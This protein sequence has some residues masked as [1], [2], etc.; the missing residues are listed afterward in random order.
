[1]RAPP[2]AWGTRAAA[3]RSWMATTLSDS[4][5]A[6]SGR[7]TERGRSFAISSG[8]QSREP[9]LRRARANRDGVGELE[10]LAQDVTTLLVAGADPLGHRAGGVGDECVRTRR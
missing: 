7:W 3:R 1:D 10:Q 2:N 5:G 6:E 4:D 8:P 9:D